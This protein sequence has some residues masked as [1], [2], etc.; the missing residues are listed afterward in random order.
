[1]PGGEEKT[2]SS[3]E[4]KS[5]VEKTTIE[6]LPDD[7]RCHI[8]SFLLTRDAAATSLMSKKWKPLWLSLRSFEFSTIYF[9]DFGKFSD[10]VTS[11]L[12]SLHSVPSL[13]LS[14][15]CCS[16]FKV[17]DVNQFLY[18]VALQGIQELHLHL[19]TYS[20]ILP[21]GFCK[22][23]VTLE[24]HH[25]SLNYFSC[26]D[27]PL[28]KS[29]SLIFVNFESHAVMFKFLSGCPNLEYLDARHLDVINSDIPTVFFTLT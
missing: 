29:L 18:Q 9:T 27:F 7:L 4:S 23:L 24:L 20:T 19:F 3:G 5:E 26:V 1:M 13:R 15:Y 17:V 2:K 22:N 16:P 28:I 12:S 6:S 25:A 10:F 11:V 8:L 21:N 14:C